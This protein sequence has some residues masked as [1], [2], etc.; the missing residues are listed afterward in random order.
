MADEAE[1]ICGRAP[2]DAEIAETIRTRANQYLGSEDVSLLNSMKSSIKDAIGDTP[3]EY[4]V[5]LNTRMESLSSVVREELDA[6]NN[7][8]SLKFEAEQSDPAVKRAR[9]DI[10]N[11]R[12]EIKDINV[13]LEKFESKDQN[14]SR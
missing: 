11:L 5:D 4:E 7:L 2:I 14:T 13:K 3:G 10:E 9:V 12:N 8:D 1:C 6:R